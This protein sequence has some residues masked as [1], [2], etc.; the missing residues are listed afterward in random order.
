M[1]SIVGLA[2][3]ALG[4]VVGFVVWAGTATI[5]A[6]ATHASNREGAQGY[7]MIAAGL[8]GAVAGMVV[9]LLLYGRSAPTGQGAAY[10]GSGVLGATGCGGPDAWRRA[11]RA[12]DVDGRAALPRAALQR[13]TPM[14]RRPGPS[15]WYR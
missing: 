11:G 10:A 6:V 4:A 1:R 5:I 7:V 14:Q 13:V 8:L 9:A 3:A 15:M 12:V 2:W